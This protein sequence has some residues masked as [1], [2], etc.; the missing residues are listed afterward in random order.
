MDTTL[1]P[2]IFSFPI[3]LIGSFLFTLSIIDLANKK[4]IFDG[5]NNLKHHCEKVSSL[6]GISIFSSFWIAIS[7]VSE[8]HSMA[9]FNYFFVG[10]FILFLTG[11][12]DDLVGI[13]AFTRLAIQV[14]VASLM[15][16]G[17]IRL[18]YIPGLEVEVPIL[19][20][21]FLTIFLIGAIVN[22]YNFIDGI[23]GLAGGLTIISA[24]AFAVLFYFS[25]ME[26]YA[27]LAVALAGSVFGF[28]WFNFGK[29]KIFMGDNGSTFIGII[30]SFFTIVFFQNHAQVGGSITCSPLVVFSFLILPLADITR[31]V[32]GRISSAHS[33][34][35]GDR[36]HIHHLMLNTGLGQCPI[37]WV[38][39][40]WSVIVIAASFLLLPQSI[41]IGSLMLLLAGSLP[42]VLLNIF[43][44]T[45]KEKQSL[46]VS[47]TK[48]EEAL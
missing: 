37:C 42:Y 48:V 12:K 41:V 6:G 34:F 19:V 15:F 20:S 7:L 3:S 39:Y 24:L 28:L 46:R 1:V 44:R 32:L 22:A 25:G 10:A 9:A 8:V 11:V 26:N 38:L 27:A 30:L 40:T 47:A 36:T 35:K 43:L 21:Y 31:V 2:R 33:P 29:A 18:T 14:G 4:K 23:N 45:K 17:G 5:N 16:M 13:S